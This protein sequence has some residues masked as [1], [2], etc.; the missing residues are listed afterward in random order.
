MDGN[1]LQVS[2]TE[3]Y[4]RLGTAKAPLLIDVRRAPAFA[5]DDRCLQQHASGR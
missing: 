3:L 2:A 1:D 4:A 5:S